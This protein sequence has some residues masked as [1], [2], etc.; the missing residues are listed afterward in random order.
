VA[1]FDI[2]QVTDAAIGRWEANVDWAI[3]TNL[4]P[5]WVADA[6]CTVEKFSKEACPLEAACE[7]QFGVRSETAM[8]KPR[9]LTIPNAPGGT[10]TLIVLN[11]GPR[12]EVVNYRVTLTSPGSDSGEGPA[13]VRPAGVAQGRKRVAR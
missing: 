6:A 10:R 2:A 7:C 4:L 12:E 11:L 5:M 1:Y 9:L 8:P 3:S 13:G